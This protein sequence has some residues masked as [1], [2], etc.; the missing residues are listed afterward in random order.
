MFHLV[1]SA[2]LSIMYQINFVSLKNNH[3][4]GKTSKK[5]KCRFKG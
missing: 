5:K 1:M 4:Y 2:L 3:D